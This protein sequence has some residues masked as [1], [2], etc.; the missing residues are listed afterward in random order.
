MVDTFNPKLLAALNDGCTL[1]HATLYNALVILNKDNKRYGDKEA[2][3]TM[4]EFTQLKES[5]KLK[6][7]KTKPK[8]IRILHREE[9]GYSILYGQVRCYKKTP[10]SPPLE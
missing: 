10:N 3:P 7:F 4:S 5:G 2:Q 8:G 9:E 6:L 1:I